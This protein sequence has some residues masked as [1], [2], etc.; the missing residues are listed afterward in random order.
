M[1]SRPEQQSTNLL[2]PGGCK[3]ILRT[4]LNPELTRANTKNW[5]G[6][7]GGSLKASNWGAQGRNDA[8]RAKTAVAKRIR[9]EKRLAQQTSRRLPRQNGLTQPPAM[10]CTRRRSHFIATRRLAAHMA[11]PASAGLAATPDMA[12]N[13]KSQNHLRSS[14]FDMN[15]HRMLMSLHKSSII[16]MEGHFTG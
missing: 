9:R 5:A 4:P 1:A 2:Q 11:L 3:P 12:M 10:C 15:P 7:Q 16:P 6:I 8:L 13:F 14:W